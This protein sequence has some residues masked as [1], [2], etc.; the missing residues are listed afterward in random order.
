MSD[1]VESS[2]EMSP[3]PENPSA[4]I[5][6]ALQTIDVIV[7]DRGPRVAPNILSGAAPPVIDLYTGPDGE[8]VLRVDVDLRYGADSFA[9]ERGLVVH[10]LYGD[11]RGQRLLNRRNRAAHAVR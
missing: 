9:N 10:A 7:D 5:I 11:A 6:T 3:W 1:L 4:E 2:I 8:P